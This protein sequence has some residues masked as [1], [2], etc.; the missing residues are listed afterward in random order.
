MKIDRKNYKHWLYLLRSAVIIFLTLPVRAVQKENSVILYGHKLNG[1]LLALYDFM[2]AKNGDLE[3][4][5]L[6]MDPAYYKQLKQA[7]VNVLHMGSVSDMAAVAKAGA[8]ITDHGM[9]TLILYQYLTSIKFIDVWHGLSYKGFD[10]QTFRH[11]HGHDEVWV[12]SETMRH[13]YIHKFG[14]SNKQIKVTGYGRSDRLI[15]GEFDRNAIL[16]KYELA[17]RK[18]ILLAPTWAQDHKNRSVLPFGVSME[19]FFDALEDVGNRNNATVIFRTHLNTGDSIK[20][21]KYNHIRVMP[22]LLYPVA[23]EFLFVSDLLVTD[24]SSMATDYLVLKR[25]TIFLDVAAPFSKGYT[26][27]PEHR[28][29]EIVDSMEKLIMNIEKYIEKPDVFLKKYE[30]QMSH[31]IHVAYGST[32]D[33]RARDRYLLNLKKMIPGYRIL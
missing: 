18:T 26:L 29:G 9:H 33:G 21:D 14:F 31:T 24:W 7:D 12:Q 30:K 20:V 16:E 5:F 19:A 15:L 25:P 1:N 10:A 28:F 32:F 8:I 13:F 22:S 4:F 27:G 6:T 11:L 23:E 3:V 2:L 17:D